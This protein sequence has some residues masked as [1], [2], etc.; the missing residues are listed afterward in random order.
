MCASKGEHFFVSSPDSSRNQL[1]IERDAPV[2]NDIARRLKGRAPQYAR[3]ATGLC[4]PGTAGLNQHRARRRAAVSGGNGGL[5]RIG[6]A[7]NHTASVVTVTSDPINLGKLGFSHL[8]CRLHAAKRIHNIARRGHGLSRP[9]L[10]RP[11]VLLFG[12]INRA[13]TGTGN[14][15]PPTEC[16]SVA[17][18]KPPPLKVLVEKL[19]SKCYAFHIKGGH[20]LTDKRAHKRIALILE[21]FPY[22]S[23]YHEEFLIFGGTQT[24]QNDGNALRIVVGDLCQH[25]FN[26]H[27]SNLACACEI[28][29]SH[30]GLAMDSLAYFHFSVR[31][32]KEWRIWLC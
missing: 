31:D 22:S 19:K 25:A 30:P 24:V 8:D 6:R 14:A 27:R 12:G 13:F 26:Q 28:P 4:R 20:V 1:G 5:I 23:P 15:R 7:F 11:E 18:G 29:L 17:R 2:P 32:M 9:A 10:E 3:R 16:G 21:Q